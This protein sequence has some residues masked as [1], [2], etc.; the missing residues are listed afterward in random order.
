MGFPNRFKKLRK[1]AGLT[2]K[3]LGKILNMGESTIS[4]YE[5]GD[6]EPSHKTLKKLAS[7]FNCSI[8][9]LLG[10]KKESFPANKIK[11]A[12]SDDPELADFWDKLSQ[13][14]DL[15]LLFKQ[16]K[17]MDP[18]GVKQI[19]RIIKAIEDEEQERYNS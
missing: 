11:S 7:F 13:R 19:I 18:A 16:T 3:E 14:E 6:R 17:D 9:F 15:Q 10:N 2:Q 8:D 12:I 4:H 5:N 1:E